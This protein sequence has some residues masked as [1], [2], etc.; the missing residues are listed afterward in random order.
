MESNKNKIIILIAIA[1]L[2]FCS[3]PEFNYSKKE[4]YPNGNIKEKRL[5]NIKQEDEAIFKYSKEGDTLVLK[6]ILHPYTAIARY[7]SD[8]IDFSFYG[9]GKDKLHLQEFILYSRNQIEVIPDKSSYIYVKII[10]DSIKFIH[11]GYELDKFKIV[12]YDKELNGKHIGD[13]II[14]KN[15]KD[16]SIHKNKIDNY[17]FK[18]LMYLHSESPGYAIRSAYFTVPKKIKFQEFFNLNSCFD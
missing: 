13:T 10:N 5:W 1:F 11:T 6:R 2:T 9:I 12:A 3:S 8:T 18:G 4:L 17:I 14:S 7:Y 15:N 16:V